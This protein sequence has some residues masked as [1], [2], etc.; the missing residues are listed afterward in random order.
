MTNHPEGA[1]ANTGSRLTTGRVTV[2]LDPP[3]GD[4]QSAG[5]SKQPRAVHNFTVDLKVVKVGRRDY[6]ARFAY[7][8]TL[9]GDGSLDA[10]TLYGF[11]TK[12]YPY[13]EHT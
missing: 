8:V 2:D 10:L 9:Y 1:Q 12:G 4:W 3:N 5:A 6:H 11:D 7:A 13:F